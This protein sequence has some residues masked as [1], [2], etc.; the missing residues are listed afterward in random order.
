MH[1]AGVAS[2]TPDHEPLTTRTFEAPQHVCFTAWTVPQRVAAWWG[3][4]GFRAVAETVTIEP[5]VGGRYDLCMIQASDGAA[6]WIRNEIVDLVEPELLVLESPPMPEVGR[7]EPVLTRVA[8]EGANG[9]TRMTLYRPYPFDR[10]SSAAAGW[11]SSF[12]KLE[13]LLDGAT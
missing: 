11:N 4:G 6:F 7:P 8:F 1:S 9:R 3:P 13:A 12:D 5:R 2:T 10:R